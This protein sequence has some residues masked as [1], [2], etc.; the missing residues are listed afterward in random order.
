MKTKMLVIAGLALC[1]GAA[2]AAPTSGHQSAI[3]Q[4]VSDSARPQADTSR[5][6]GR[7]PAALLAFAGV[8]K[9]MTVVDLLP[10]AGYF[11]RIFAKAVGPKG[12]VYAYFGSQYDARL[13]TQGKDPDMQFTDL[14]ALYPNLDVIH[15]PL[16]NFVTPEPVDLVW[17]SDN[18]HDM[19]NT[20]TADADIAAANKG[21]FDSLKHGGIY[22][23]VDHRAAK[24]AGAGSTSALHRMDE[25]IAKKEI[26]AAGFKLVAESK[27]LTNP[28]DDNTKRVFEQGEHDHTDQ[29][30]LKFRKP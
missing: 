2:A 14:K 29:F 3:D 26:E 11:T 30:V 28:S 19:H 20:P 1:G 16:E 22:M 15:G 27:I 5:D 17:T 9:G 10:G 13:K 6:V 24:G 4:A 21:I 23:V 12:R 7:H 8:R 18:Y 25:D